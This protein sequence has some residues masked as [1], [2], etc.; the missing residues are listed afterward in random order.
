MNERV[1]TTPTQQQRKVEKANNS[2]MA[3]NLNEMK[4]LGKEMEETK[5]GSELRE[6][7]LTQD[8]QQND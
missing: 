8:P 1:K 6:E 5:T 4:K 3:Q 7:N 2:S